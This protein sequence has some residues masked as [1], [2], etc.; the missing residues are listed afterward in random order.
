M[1]RFR[2]HGRARVGIRVGATPSTARV[3]ARNTAWTSACGP[4]LMRLWTWKL[5]PRAIA[6]GSPKH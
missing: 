5:S 3:A 1:S 6:S 4:T 2:I